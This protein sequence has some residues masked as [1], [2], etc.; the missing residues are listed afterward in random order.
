MTAVGVWFWQPMTPGDWGWMAVLCV[1]GATG[2]WLLIRAYEVAEASAVQP[3]AFLQ[4]VFAGVLGI[5]VF[6]DVLSA[7][8][9]VGGAVVV[10]AGLFTLWRA[11][12]VAAGPTQA[13]TQA[14]TQGG[15]RAGS[16]AGSN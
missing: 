6:G 16:Q 11:G 13:A 14:P 8:I 5:T 2:H 4:L 15:S 1:T 10:A 7:N 9:V 12:R 3:F